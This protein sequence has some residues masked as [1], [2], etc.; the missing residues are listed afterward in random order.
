MAFVNQNENMLLNAAIEAGYDAMLAPPSVY[1]TQ[2]IF[3]YYAAM[4]R[5]KSNNKKKRISKIFVNSNTEQNNM[6]SICFETPKF[7]E[8]LKTNCNHHFCI[9]CYEK[10]YKVSMSSRSQKV[11]CPYCRHNEPNVQMYAQKYKPVKKPPVQVVK[12]NDIVYEDMS[13][14]L[15]HNKKTKNKK[16]KVKSSKSNNKKV[17]TKGWK[18][19][20]CMKEMF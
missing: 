2:A 12:S 13:I 17:H 18:D 3:D 4:R 8:L 5:K 14:E 19:S 7:N 15:K 11:S 20:R 10:W 9:P 1:R 16:T 6:C